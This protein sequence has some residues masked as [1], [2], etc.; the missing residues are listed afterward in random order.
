M[1]LLRSMLV[2][3]GSKYDSLKVVNVYIN[4][5]VNDV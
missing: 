3:G 1:T 5:N 4:V 2:N